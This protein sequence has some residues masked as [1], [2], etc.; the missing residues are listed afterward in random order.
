[1]AGYLPLEAESSGACV[2]TTYSHH[3]RARVMLTQLW[4][5]ELA[6]DSRG[7]K[8]NCVHPGE[9]RTRAGGL[10]RPKL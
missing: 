3:H 8:V 5:K 2:Q 4:A 10:V 7:I 1:M 6:G 9:A